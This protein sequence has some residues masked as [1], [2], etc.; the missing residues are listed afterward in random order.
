MNHTEFN[1]SSFMGVIGE[2]REDKDGI[3]IPGELMPSGHPVRAKGVKKHMLMQG[4]D[5]KNMAMQ[6]FESVKG[7]YEREEEERDREA[8]KPDVPE[9]V[10]GGAD[11]DSRDPGTSPSAEAPVV[12][13]LEEELQARCERWQAVMDKAEADVDRAQKRYDDAFSEYRRAQRALDAIRQ[14]D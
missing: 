12:Q 5:A 1:Y 7:A 2:T 10:I 11:S 6:W 13:T 14:E 8:S 9:L 3:Y 4:E